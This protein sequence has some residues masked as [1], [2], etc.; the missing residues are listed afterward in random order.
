MTLFEPFDI[1]RP[2][3]QESYRKEKETAGL[4]R[5][6]EIWLLKNTVLQIVL[7]TFLNVSGGPGMDS[8][9]TQVGETASRI[10]VIK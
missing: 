4:W 9:V 1:L 10:L 5:D 8:N 7:S 2:S 3:N 6:L